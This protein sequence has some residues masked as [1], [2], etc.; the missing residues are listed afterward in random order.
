M[1]SL[2]CYKRTEQN[3][4]SVIVNN[5]CKSLFNVFDTFYG[6]ECKRIVLWA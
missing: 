1:K 5:V 6:P 4:L 3:L 2:S